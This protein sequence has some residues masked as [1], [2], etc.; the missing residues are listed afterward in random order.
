VGNLCCRQNL[1][2]QETGSRCQGCIEVYEANLPLT[3]LQ[4]IR[5]SATNGGDGLVDAARL[6]SLRLKDKTGALLL[7]L[8]DEVL[9]MKLGTRTL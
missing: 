2:C 3:R 9:S 4:S 8:G 5:Q 6:N 7:L 1:E